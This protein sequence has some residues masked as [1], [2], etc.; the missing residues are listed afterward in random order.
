MKQGE[1][2]YLLRAAMEGILPA[3]VLA[4]R[5]K[6]GFPVPQVGWIYH[7]LRGPIRDLLRVRNL[8][9]GIFD[10][11]RLRARFEADASSENAAAAGFWFRVISFL[12]WRCG[13]RPG[14]NRPGTSGKFNEGRPLHAGAPEVSAAGGRGRT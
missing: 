5:V 3:E 8:G 12:L 9:D 11:P 14:A 1:N 2:K 6:Y 7:N 4:R 13:H 10:E